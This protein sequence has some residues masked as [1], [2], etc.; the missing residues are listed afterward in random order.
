VAVQN[1]RIEYIALF[2]QDSVCGNLVH[3]LC[4]ALRL[5]LDFSLAAMSAFH[6]QSEAVGGAVKA[7][8]RR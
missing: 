2:F 1:H 7:M 5:F 6:R 8:W 4:D 3:D